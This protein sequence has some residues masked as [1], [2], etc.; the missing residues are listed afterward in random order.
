VQGELPPVP[1]DRGEVLA[2]LKALNESAMRT[3]V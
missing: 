1:K 3:T 2:M